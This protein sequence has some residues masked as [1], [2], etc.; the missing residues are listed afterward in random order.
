[1]MGN[2]VCDK[3]ISNQICSI[4]DI[5]IPWEGKCHINPNCH[6]GRFW[7]HQRV[8]LPWQ[9]QHHFICVRIVRAPLLVLLQE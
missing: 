9:S 3:T 4:R 2:D 8:P 1:M 5:Q 6:D 7:R